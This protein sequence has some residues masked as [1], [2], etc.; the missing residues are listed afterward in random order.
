M[1][2][3]FSNRLIILGSGTSQGVPVIGCTC[4]V[5][6]S[7]NPKD[8]RLRSSIYVEYNNAK[9]LVD[10]GP[11]FRQQML[12]SCITDIDYVLLTHEHNDHVAGLDDI[13]PFNFKHQKIIPIYSHSRVISDIR[14]R[15]SYVFMEN[16]YP[17]TPRIE[18]NVI[19]S[20]NSY[21]FGENARVEVL[22]VWHGSLEVFAYVFGDIA[23]VCDVSRIDEEAL[24]KLE[25]LST[26][27][28]SALHHRAHPAHFT[29]EQAVHILERLKPKQAFIT[30]MSHEMG[31]HD[32]ILSI[33][34][35][36][37]KPAYDGME[38]L[39]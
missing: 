39:F 2:I 35:S 34:P 4:Q 38:I 9:F 25:N 8:N 37:I 29:L 30:H 13:R 6:T 32:H 28:I 16:P 10:I 15:F 22:S 12:R 31:K 27:I 26:I 1:M 20:N 7:A 14:S 18:T 5:C 17:G 36:Y 21:C 19:E 23:Y 3:P 33:L 11:D 24:R